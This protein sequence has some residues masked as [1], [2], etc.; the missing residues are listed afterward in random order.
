MSSDY[1]SEGAELVVATE[2]ARGTAPSSGYV[3]LQVDVG[4]LSGFERKYTDVE[5]DIHSLNATQEK[6]D[7]VAYEVTPSLTHDINKDFIDAIAAPAFRCTAKHIGGTGLSLFRPTVVVDGGVGVDYFTVASLGAIPNGM[8][9]RT[10]GFIAAA[11]NGTFVTSG[12]ST[13]VEIRVA[14]GTLT[15][16]ASPPANATL[17]VVGVQGAAGDLELS[18]SGHLTSTALDFTTLGLVVGMWLYLPSATQALAMG[19]AL[20]AFSNAAY[21]GRA[22]ITAIAANQLTLERHTWT[23]GAGTTETTSTVRVFIS[24]RFYRNYP[25]DNSVYNEYTLSFEKT[26]VKPGVSA[27]TRYTMTK[28]CGAN[29]LQIAAPIDSKITAT[30]GLVGMTATTPV[31]VASR[32]A[33]PSTAYAPLGDALQ[34]T[35]NDLYEVRLTDSGGNLVADVVDWT[36]NLNNNI[37][38]R[39]SQGVFGASGLNYGKFMFSVNMKAYYQDSDAIDAADANRDG[40]HW[41]AFTANHQYGLLLDMPNVALRNPDLSYAA[42]EP[43]MINCD[44]VGF[45]S[46]TDGIAGAMAVFGYIPTDV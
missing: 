16:E 25:I 44:I 15:A 41:D 22:R 38:P 26:D 29:T 43:V 14:T 45:R 24:S 6:G 17:D 30:L 19:D 7:H 21:T 46:A 37:K 4:G 10:R 12:T 20:Y 33:G 5:R 27:D 13:G 31:A 28:G 1:I 23:L 3:K 11:N 35:Q 40:M 8:L 34:D 42:N 18:A 32:V 39:K 9:I 36:Y 2:S